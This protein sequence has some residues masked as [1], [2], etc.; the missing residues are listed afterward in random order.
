[1]PYLHVKEIKKMKI[2]ITAITLLCATALMAQ[3]DGQPYTISGVFAKVKSGK[4]FLTVYDGDQPK[5]DSANIVNGRFIFKGNLSKPS[6]AILYMPSRKND[7]LQFYADPG[8]MMISGPGDSLKI[9]KVTGSKTTDDD[10]KLSGMLKPINEWESRNY[11]V[12]KKADAAKNQKVLDSLDELDE[13]IML[14]R[15]KLVKDFVEH[16][17][18]S[19][20]SAIAIEENY[21]YYAEAS[22][23]E[24]LYNILSE[25][26][27]QSPSGQSVKKMLDVYKTIAVGM[28][29][30]DIKQP[31]TDGKDISLS[32]LKGK[33]VLVDFWA[34]WCGPCRKENP[35]IV[36]AYNQYKDKGFEILG[37]SYD[38]KKDRWEG[39][40]KKDGLAWP[41]VSD[42]KG[43]Q[44]ATAEIYHIKA[45][46]SNLLVDKEGRIVAKNL[47]G[48]KLYSKLAEIFP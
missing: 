45:I 38:N 15:R 35:N 33:Y 37:V 31:G 18:A 4:I 1:L 8:V 46:P 9:L 7:W 27:K 22:D 12:Y 3:A 40:I 44:N 42:L 23:V 20:R 39:A 47:L 24:P 30:P 14:E 36:K 11:E 10:R 43:W 41:Q 16:N 48:K 34:S 29:A 26:V 25:K 5:K 21:G 19:M 17:T 32:S 2:L 13:P 28:V 6:M